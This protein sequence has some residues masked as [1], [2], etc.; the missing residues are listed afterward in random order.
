[1]RPGEVEALRSWY[2]GCGHRR[3]HR[4]ETSSASTLGGAGEAA[5]G[6]VAEWLQYME[7][8]GVRCD[9][10]RGVYRNDGNTCWAGATLQA[11]LHVPCLVDCVRN[12]SCVAGGAPCSLCLLKRSEAE[13]ASPGTTATVGHWRPFVEQ[14]RPPFVWGHQQCV[15]E[16][17]D[18]LFAG[19]EP[20]ELLALQGHIGVEQQSVRTSRFKCECGVGPQTHTTAEPTLNH[21]MLEVGKL[22]AAHAESLERLFQN[23]SAEEKLDDSHYPCPACDEGGETTRRIEVTRTNNVLLVSIKRSLDAEKGPP[24]RSSF[25]RS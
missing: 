21:L 15:L 3:Q 23:A 7:E 24:L 9:G 16:Y 17:V 10:A 13:T 25:A 12:H 11:M 5:R 2:L 1:M 18:G 20:L 8:R 6:A 4:L 14:L 19:A 22:E